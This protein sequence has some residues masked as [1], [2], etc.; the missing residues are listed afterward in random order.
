MTT[1]QLSIIISAYTNNSGY[2][3][4]DRT[5]EV[6]Q[7][8]RDILHDEGMIVSRTMNNPAEY[9]FSLTEKGETWYK[10][11]LEIPFPIMKTIYVIE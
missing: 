5:T 4:F 3:I 10:H 1:L 7:R 9:P 6:Y 8:Q 2:D 11:I